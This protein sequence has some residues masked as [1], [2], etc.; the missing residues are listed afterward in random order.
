MDAGIVP[1]DYCLSR[2][3]NFP[4]GGEVMMTLW[5]VPLL[6]EIGYPVGTQFV[7]VKSALVCSAKP[8]ENDDQETTVL[9]P[10]VV[11]AN[12]GGP[13]IACISIVSVPSPLLALIKSR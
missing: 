11:I 1:G 10:L 3:N 7:V 6:M 4:G 9:V 12:C 8:V 5:F 13:T 2:K